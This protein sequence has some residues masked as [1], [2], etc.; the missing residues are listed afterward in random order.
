MNNEQQP[1]DLLHG[2]TLKK[3]VTELVDKHGW[4]YLA[5]RVRV[6]CFVKSP[7]INS[8]LKLLRHNPW[9]RDKV[10]RIYIRSILK[11]KPKPLPPRD[12]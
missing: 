7:T 8:S 1:N 11:K 9:A 12:K 10:E 3:I 6:N 5:E 4:A 2:I